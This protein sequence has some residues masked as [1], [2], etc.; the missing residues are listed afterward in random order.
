MHLQRELS[1]WALIHNQFQKNQMKPVERDHSE[2]VGKIGV[3]CL[4]DNTE[5]DNGVYLEAAGS[6]ITATFSIVSQIVDR[7]RAEIEIRNGRSK[8]ERIIKQTIQ[9]VKPD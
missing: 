8:I 5:C 4:E 3:C 6:V 7:E 1:A 2:R 9:P